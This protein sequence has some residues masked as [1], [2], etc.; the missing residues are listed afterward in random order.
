[1][2]HRRWTLLGFL[3]LLTMPSVTDAVT[4]QL[5][6]SATVSCHVNCSTVTWW[7]KGIEVFQIFQ[8]FEF[9]EGKCTVAPEFK[10]R[11]ECSEEK[12]RG[13]DVSLTITSAVYN[14]RGWY[15]CSC[16]GKDQCDRR[17]DV[18]VPISLST[19]AG[20]KVTLPCYAEMDKRTADSS[21]FVLWEKD[22]QQV[23]QLEN[24]K[25]S[26]GSGFEQRAR[27]STENYRK[28]DLSL[29]IDRVRFSDSGLYR[30]SL[31]DGGH[32]Y[33]NTISLAVEAR[34]YVYYKK[35]G[36][37]VLL[38][39]M[40]LPP[41]MVYFK[42]GEAT[43]DSWMCTRPKDAVHCKPDYEQRT[44]IMNNSLMLSK[45][46]VADSGIYTVMDVK[47]DEVVAIHKLAVAGLPSHKI[48]VITAS[49]ACVFVVLLGAL[50]WSCHQKQRK[51]EKKKDL[52]EPEDERVQLSIQQ[53]EN[54]L[55]GGAGPIKGHWRARTRTEELK[56]PE[57]LHTESLQDEVHSFRNLL[58]LCC[59]YDLSKGKK[60]E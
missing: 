2:R 26:Y 51:T 29:T 60:A 58:G 3:A 4:V 1:M 35:V 46:T 28:G 42:E 30:C 27:V 6:H 32:G 20:S 15:Y 17:I 55:L 47:S 18:L 31:K 33:P 45:L 40:V 36:D 53:T 8:I 5:G 37:S 23:L 43:A 21:A 10:D 56:P 48:P 12:I 59:L 52:T 44:S 54:D 39:L 38:D 7:S 22:K 57:T 24:G 34:Q 25:M 50:L 11:I 41:V 13:G 9:S 14:D 49:V 16:D 19:S